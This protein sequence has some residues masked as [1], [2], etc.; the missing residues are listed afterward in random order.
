M[1]SKTE[2]ARRLGIDRGT[3]H[4]W[5]IGQTKPEDP[6]TV[7]KFAEALK[8]DLEEALAAAGLRPGQEAPTTATRHETP[9]EREIRIIWES[10][11]PAD[12]KRRLIEHVKARQERDRKARAEEIKMIA[13]A[14]GERWRNDVD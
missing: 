3:V 6:E 9:D 4:R 10:G 12:L 8:L 2:L 11:L 7:R 14:M 1:L 5:E 13:E